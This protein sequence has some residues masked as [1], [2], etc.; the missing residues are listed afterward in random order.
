MV[1]F[2]TEELENFILELFHVCMSSEFWPLPLG[3]M[4]IGT[5]LPKAILALVN[6]CGEYK[7]PRTPTSCGSQL[8]VNWD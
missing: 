1:K 4:C 3:S 8:H 7:Y 2:L 6:M 5:D